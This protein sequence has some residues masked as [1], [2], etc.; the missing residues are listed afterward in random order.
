MDIDDNT[1]KQ[2]CTRTLVFTESSDD[3]S[4]FDK[5]GESSF[6]QTSIEKNEESD[7][8]EDELRQGRAKALL[9]EVFLLLGLHKVSD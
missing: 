1:T 5:S 4:L 6:L 3:D 2:R 9:N 7:G 8:I